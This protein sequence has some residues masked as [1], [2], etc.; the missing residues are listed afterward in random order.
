MRDQI[1][2]L[3]LLSQV[4]KR[5]N[6]PIGPSQQGK[7]FSLLIILAIVSSTIDANGSL[8]VIDPNSVSDF[9][10]QLACAGR[11]RTSLR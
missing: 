9:G 1:Q 5:A 10:E 6:F 8:F 2:E 3:A 7:K 4:S 11:I